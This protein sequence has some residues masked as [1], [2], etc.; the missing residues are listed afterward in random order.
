MVLATGILAFIVGRLLFPAIA[1]TDIQYI[2]AGLAASFILL[3]ILLI[4][5]LNDRPEV[6]V[7]TVLLTIAVSFLI[8]RFVDP[9]L[10]QSP[11]TELLCPPCQGCDSGRDLRLQFE[12]EAKAWLQTGMADSDLKKKAEL[13]SGAE[14]FARQCTQT[15]QSNNATCAVDGAAELARIRLLQARVF[16]SSGQCSQALDG[17]NEAEQLTNGSDNPDLQAGVQSAR[18]SYHALCDATPTPTITATVTHTRTPTKTSTS[19]ATFTST[20][21]GT[22]TSTPTNTPTGTATPRPLSL[23]LL[24]SRVEDGK[25]FLSVRV[26]ENGLYAPG[27][28]LG[29]YTMQVNGASLNILDINEAKAAGGG[30]AIVAV[31]DDSGSIAKHS[32][33]IRDAIRVLNQSAGE[34]DALGMVLFNEDVQSLQRPI[35]GQRISEDSIKQITGTGD[36]SNYSRIW[37]GVLQGITDTLRSGLQNKYIILLSDGDDI[38]SDYAADEKPEDRVGRLAQHAFNNGVVVDTLRLPPADSR[39]QYE[40]LFTTLMQGLASNTFGEYREA[41]D[42]D[43][44]ALLIRTIVGKTQSYYALSIDISNLGPGSYAGRLQV[45]G[46]VLEIGFNR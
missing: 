30:S 11:L 24:D 5:V 35:A 22:A 3:I 39:R 41:K 1:C 45:E 9:I 37:D 28:A 17:L 6:P 16:L 18:Q 46:G 27:L 31:V 25:L 21:T 19:T 33:Q 40:R 13:L 8:P 20:A 4:P 26:E 32:S 10:A 7:A 42:Y 12:Q 34:N 38:F 23:T 2:V 44:V 15:A 29:E 14:L 43:A 36:R